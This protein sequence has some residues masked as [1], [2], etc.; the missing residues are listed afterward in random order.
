MK[1]LNKKNRLDLVLFLVIIINFA[2]IACLGYQNYQL[3]KNKL[4]LE[5]ELSQTKENFA[6]TTKN[7]QEIIDSVEWDLSQTK[8]EKDNFEIKYNDER[9]R[10]DLFASQIGGIQ[11]AVGTLEKLSQTDP[12]LLKKYSKVYFLSEN[13][14]PE[15]FVKIDQK[16]TYDSKEDYL[17]YARVWPFLQDMLEIAKNASP[18]FDLKII[19]AYRSFGKQSEL[20]SSYTVIYGSGANKFSADQGYSEH[21]LGTTV[22]FTVPEIGASYS[23][24]DKT[25]AYQWL[26]ENAYRYGFILS[27][28]ENNKYYQFEPWHWRFVGRA[29]AEKLH[30]ES[31]NFYDLDQREIDQYL[32]SFFD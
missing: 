17:F 29:L 6:S 3:K 7:L 9:T 26:L 24:F 10:M 23:D 18:D 4:V 22:D 11:G 32:I 2:V 15:T 16:Y 13:Y 19:S 21:Q 5:N 28:P 30:Q 25:S 1:N 12:E 8:I 31:K 14:V 27:Y 20:K